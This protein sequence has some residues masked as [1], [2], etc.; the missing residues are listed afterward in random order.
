L[1][2]TWD[3]ITAFGGDNGYRTLATEGIPNSS[4]VGYSRTQPGTQHE[5]KN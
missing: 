2:I 5:R 4:V 1:K 3:A